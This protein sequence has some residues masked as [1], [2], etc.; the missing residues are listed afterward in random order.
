[1][2]WSY[3]LLSEQERILFRRLSVFAGGFTLEAAE[4]ICSDEGIAVGEVLDVLAR[5]VD[6]SLVVVEEREG[7]RR[8]RLLETIRQYSQERLWEAGEVARLQEQHWNWYTAL[9]EQ[10][11]RELL[12]PK[13]VAW[14]NRFESEHD[15]LRAARRYLL[16]R[17]EAAIAARIAGGA[18]WH[19]WL[20][21]G[22]LTEG[23]TILERILAQF[24]E[25]SSRGPGARAG[26]ASASNRTR[27]PGHLPGRRIQDESLRSHCPPA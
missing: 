15:N 7:E 21:R 9:V 17:G 3:S 8:Y 5:L 18:F 12:G 4:A 22:Y 19:F 23:R 27:F 16:E 24:S 26:H 1:M 14:F 13:Q 20:Y 10:A 6:K 25:R 2:D 11:E